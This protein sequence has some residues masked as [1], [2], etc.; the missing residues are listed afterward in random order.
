MYSSVVVRATEI[1]T[2]SPIGFIVFAI[3]FGTL[4][5]CLALAAIGGGAS[6]G[7]HVCIVSEQE[8]NEA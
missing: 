1:V 2:L 7:P 3:S 8:L 6:I 5:D 4:I